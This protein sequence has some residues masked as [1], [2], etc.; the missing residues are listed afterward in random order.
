MGQIIRLPVSLAAYPS[1]TPDLNPAECVFLTGLRCWAADLRLGNDPL[2]RLTRVLEIAQA[3]DAARPL[4]RFMIVALHSTARAVTLH[5]PCCSTVGG[6]EAHLLHAASLVQAGTRE[7]AAD[8]LQA[9]LLTTQGA[10]LALGPLEEG[11]DA[12]AKA[13]LFFRRRQLACPDPER[14]GWGDAGVPLPPGTLH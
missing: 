8:A 11:A 2:D 1:T 7:Q 13:R 10:V 6:D 12:F 9:S 3:P 4:D 5:C 14:S